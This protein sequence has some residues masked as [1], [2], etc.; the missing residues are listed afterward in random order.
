M[1]IV[2]NELPDN[3]YLCSKWFKLKSA[4]N[5]GIGKIVKHEKIKYIFL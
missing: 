3:W 5:R 4:I 1:V 2:D